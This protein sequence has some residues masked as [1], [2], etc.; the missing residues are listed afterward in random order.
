MRGKYNNF[1]TVRNFLIDSEKDFNIYLSRNSIK[2]HEFNGADTIK[3]FYA[4]N[5]L[6]PKVFSVVKKI[7]KQ[8]DLFYENNPEKLDYDRQRIKYYNYNHSELKKTKRFYYIDFSSCYITVLRNIKLIDNELFKTINSLPKSDRLISLGM[9]AYEPYLIQYKK[10][11][12]NENVQ[13]VKNDYSKF[14]F[15]ACHLTTD[16][17]QEVI[18]RIDNKYMFYWVDGIFFDNADIYYKVFDYLKSKKMLFR[19]GSCYDFDVVEK[20]RYY[21]ISF[22]QSDKNKFEIKRYNIPKYFQEIEKKRKINA[23]IFKGDLDSAIELFNS[24][25]Y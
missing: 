22:W 13:K 14:F 12:M 18:K 5:K 15:L 7:K 20:D 17:M 6:N 16:L 4:K 9:L 24:D 8:C 2:I 21:N 25:K 10:G 23:L 1:K 11:V 19:F 3:H